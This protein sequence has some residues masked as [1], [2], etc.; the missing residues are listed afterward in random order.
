M[1]KFLDTIKAVKEENL[2]KQQL[3]VYHKMLCEYKGEMKL[4]LATLEKAKAMF[5]VNHP[6]QTAIQRKI[7]WDSSVEGQRLI[8][9]KAFIGA[10]NANL[11]NVKARLFSV[12]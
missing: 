1:S 11:E 10:V 6:E 2:S 3:E 7:N 9:L 4:E 8:D 12:Y 5:L